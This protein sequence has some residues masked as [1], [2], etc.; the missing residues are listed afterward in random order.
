[1]G[2]TEA[3][4]RK[5]ELGTIWIAYR[6]HR[7]KQV[8]NYRAMGVGTDRLPLQPFERPIVKMTKIDEVDLEALARRGAAPPRAR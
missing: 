5:T 1:M 4:A 6:G 7:K 8:E 3:E 2:W